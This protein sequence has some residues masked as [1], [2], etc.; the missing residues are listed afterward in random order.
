[1]KSKKKTY[2]RSVSSSVSG[3]TIFFIVLVLA[4]FALTYMYIN[5]KTEYLKDLISRTAP[6][7]VDADTVP[8]CPAG[9][10]NMMVK[11]GT[12]VVGVPAH[13]PSPLLYQQGSS[14]S[15]IYGSIAEKQPPD[16]SWKVEIKKNLLMAHTENG[17]LIYINYNAPIRIRKI[18]YYDSDPS[19]KNGPLVVKFGYSNQINGYVP[20]SPTGDNM[21]GSKDLDYRLETPQNIIIDTGGDGIYMTFCM[22]TYP[23]PS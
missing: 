6:E 2:S 1:M 11:T 14:F 5:Y 22:T 18:I 8:S 9:S 7:S 12:L 13:S 16:V 15:H 23:S 20:L 3:L 21:W 10:W 19:A 17:N 4:L